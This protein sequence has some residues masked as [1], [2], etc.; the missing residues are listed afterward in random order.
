MDGRRW[1][2][3]YD[4]ENLPPSF[5]EKNGNKIRQTHI[6]AFGLMFETI[7]CNRA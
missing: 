6:S 4:A 2:A 7:V 3:V 5:E 1:K